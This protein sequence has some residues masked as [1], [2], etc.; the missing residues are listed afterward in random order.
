MA[1]ATLTPSAVLTMPVT[2]TPS[3]TA[4]PLPPT[5]T[6]IPTATLIPQGPGLDLEG[7][8]VFPWPLYAGDR[9]SVDVDPRLPAEIGAPL[10]LTWAVNAGQVLTTSVDRMGLDQRWQAR[11]YWAWQLPPEETTIPFTFTLLLPPGVADPDVTDNMLTLTV[12]PLPR[13]ALRKPE[14]ETR[15]AVMESPGFRFHYLTGSAAERDLSLITAEAA[16][17]YRDV[18]AYFGLTEEPVDI[19]LLDRIIGQGGYASAE[20]VAISYTDRHYAPVEL[21]LLLRHELVHRLDQ[22][23]GCSAAPSLLR[24]GLAVYISGGHYTPKPIARMAAAIYASPHYIPLT[25]LADNFYSSHHEIGYMEAAAFVTY[26]V[27]Q[28]GRSSLATFCQAAALGDEMATQTSALEAGLEALGEEHLTAFQAKWEAWLSTQPVAPDAIAALAAEW[29]LMEVLRAYQRTYDLSAHF[30]EGILFDPRAA[31]A[32]H[33]TADFVRRPREV[34][35]MAVEL[36]MVMAREALRQEEVAWAESL[37]GTIDALLA[38]GFPA[39]G[40]AAD[41]KAIVAATLAQGYEPYRLVPYFD[42]SYEVH[43]LVYA[44]WPARRVLKAS[45]SASEWVVV[46]LPLND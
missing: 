20:W 40:W 43:A 45:R 33:I 46:P 13:E 25:Q 10:T 6:P 37:L 21:G 19:Y 11:F 18:A 44:A 29:H 36:L 7:V 35:P 8:H 34:E 32:L 23:W 38:G 12:S 26:L 3:P 42:G 22:A 28:H 24:E 16:D 39:T 17:A 15:W 30:L 1:T 14:P 31:E 9:I 4:A 2:P 41:V 5:E 27:E